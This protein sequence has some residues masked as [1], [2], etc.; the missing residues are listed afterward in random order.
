MRDDPTDASAVIAELVA[1]VEPALVATTG[2]R[3]YGFVVGGDR[4]RLCEEISK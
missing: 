2:S 1:A 4:G 3:Y